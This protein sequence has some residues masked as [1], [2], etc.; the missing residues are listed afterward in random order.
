MVRTGYEITAGRLRTHLKQ[1][2][3]ILGEQDRADIEHVIHLLEMMQ[4]ARALGVSVEF[5]AWSSSMGSG[6]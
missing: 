5:A 1:E 4:D 2:A 6:S 3:E